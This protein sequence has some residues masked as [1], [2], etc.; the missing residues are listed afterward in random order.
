MS[1]TIFLLMAFIA[2][3]LAGFFFFQWQSQIVIAPLQEELLNNLPINSADKTA[4]PDN[5][6]K[7]TN[8]PPIPQNEKPVN[9]PDNSTNSSELCA[10]PEGGQISFIEAKAIALASDCVKEGTLKETHF[11]NPN[12]GTWWIDIAADK[13]GCNPA[14]V[15]SAADKTAE[16]NWRCTGLI[17]P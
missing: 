9:S 4:Q 17:N 15:I 1:K 12:S 16:I 7:N 11:C 2:I 13:P 3:S 14:C 10:A 6:Q 5:I 8:T